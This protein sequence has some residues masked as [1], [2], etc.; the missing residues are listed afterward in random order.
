MESTPSISAKSTVS[1]ETKLPR[2]NAMPGHQQDLARVSR[3][4]ELITRPISSSASDRSNRLARTS[5]P[6]DLCYVLPLI[7]AVGCSWS[8]TLIVHV[9]GVCRAQQAECPG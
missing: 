1:A 8:R 9:E 4:T 2:E 3:V 6:P 7:R 5:A